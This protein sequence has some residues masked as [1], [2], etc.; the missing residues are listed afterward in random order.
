M[1]AAPRI[2]SSTGTDGIHAA[3]RLQP[4]RTAHAITLSVIA[5]TKENLFTLAQGMS[6]RA[7]APD[8]YAKCHAHGI[9]TTQERDSP[10][11]TMETYTQQAP[12]STVVLGRGFLGSEFERHGYKVFG[13]D[14]FEHPCMYY[15]NALAG[16]QTIINCIGN[17]DTRACEDP[18]KWEEV[19]HVNANL[20]KRLS[21]YCHRHGKKL[22]HIS[23][24]CVYDKNNAPQN[25]ESFISSHCR[26]VVSKLAGEYACRPKDLILRPRLYFSDIPDKNN[27]LSKLPNF[28]HHLT[29]INSFT[30]TATIVEATTA[31]LNADQCG[32]FN[33]AQSGYG[34]IQQIA[35]H[36]GM[37]AK[38]PMTGEQLQQSQG[39]ALVNNILDTSKLEQFYKPRDLFSEIYRCREWLKSA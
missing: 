3:L 15:E 26:Y 18:A 14:E 35:Q 6:W 39:L 38:P 13:R 9:A 1:V 37:E 19:Y 10:L 20:P 23:T 4:F 2:Y 34:T 29:E 17:A 32:I 7:N 27:L 5:P 11:K 16:Y 33:V 28:S 30:S 31:L 21:D 22:V 36:L 24:G 12:S 25:E 8:T